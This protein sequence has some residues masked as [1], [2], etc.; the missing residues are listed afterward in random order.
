MCPSFRESSR[1]CPPIIRYGCVVTDL[2]SPT[3]RCCAVLIATSAEPS[4][5]SLLVNNGLV[6]AP[7]ILV[8]TY[9]ALKAHWSALAVPGNGSTSSR[10][11]TPPQ[12]TNFPPAPPTAP[13]MM[14]PPFSEVTSA[15]FWPL[16]PPVGLPLGF[17]VGV[18]VVFGLL[19]FPGFPHFNVYLM[20]KKLLP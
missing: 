20:E 2:T 9:V 14:M 1:P 12:G 18:G 16:G 19:G 5:F 17:G 15:S 4:R 3:F 8:S 6:G 10:S 13:P 11:T 7:P